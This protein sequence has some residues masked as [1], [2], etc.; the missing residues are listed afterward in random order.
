[1]F[2]IL[3]ILQ[4]M[5]RN[6]YMKTFSHIKN[7]TFISFILFSG[8]LI[9]Q[10][11]TYLT[12]LSYIMEIILVTN[13]IIQ[14]FCVSF[15]NFYFNKR[16]YDASS[17]FFDSFY[18]SSLYFAFTTLYTV[19]YRDIRPYNMREIIF[20][21]VFLMFGSFIYSFIISIIQLYCKKKI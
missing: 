10:D 9:C 11:S 17:I 8:F 19:G 16:K 12:I 4:W 20:I 1:M 6:I 2:R 21:I 13:F 7:C 15:H 3:L 5:K 14:N 18:S